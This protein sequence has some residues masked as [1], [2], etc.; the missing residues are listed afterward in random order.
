M[1]VKRETRVNNTTSTRTNVKHEVSLPE[2]TGNDVTR[3]RE[4]E[5]KGS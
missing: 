4:P 5:M 2:V 1:N 3:S